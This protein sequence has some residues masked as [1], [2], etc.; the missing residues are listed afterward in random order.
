MYQH[1]YVPPGQPLVQ[2]AP[3]QP[4][5]PAYPVSGYQAVAAPGYQPVVYAQP[6]SILVIQ[7]NVP[8]IPGSYPQSI[9][10]PR[11]HHVANSRFRRS[12]SLSGWIWVVILVFV[13]GMTMIPLCCV[14]FFMPSCYEGRHYCGNCGT[15]VGG[16]RR[17]GF[18]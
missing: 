18:F 9:T 12:F 13:F 14:P 16:Y 8:V 11:C 5:P 15:L 3:H 6:Q 10:C 17:H 4:Y 7:P 2:Y 1:Y